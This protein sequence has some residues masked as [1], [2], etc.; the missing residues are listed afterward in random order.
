MESIRNL[1]ARIVGLFQSKEGLVLIL[2][3]FAVFAILIKFLKPRWLMRKIGLVRTRTRRVYV[4]SRRRRSF[5]FRRRRR[6]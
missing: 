2:G 4:G 1:G 5:G 6:R 3:L